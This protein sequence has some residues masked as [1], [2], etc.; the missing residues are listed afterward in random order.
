MSFL[1]KHNKCKHY[2][3]YKDLDYCWK[4]VQQAEKEAYEEGYSQGCADSLEEVI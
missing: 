4:C 1:D 3:G 2:K